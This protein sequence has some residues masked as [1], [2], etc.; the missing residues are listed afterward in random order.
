M[1]AASN[2]R[3][4]SRCEVACGDELGVPLAAA[5]MYVTDLPD[6]LVSEL[7]DLG[8]ELVGDDG[9]ANMLL[10]SFARY[11]KQAIDQRDLSGVQKCFAVADRL[12]RDTDPE[13]RMALVGSYLMQVFRALGETNTAWARGHLSPRMAEAWHTYEK[14]LDRLPEARTL[15]G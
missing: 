6:F 1:R 15:L 8:N 10:S 5:K 14:Y 11:T 9:H 7:P 4:Q 13:L 2:A 3:S 12:L